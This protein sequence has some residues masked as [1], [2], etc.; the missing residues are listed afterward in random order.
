MKRNILIVALVIVLLIAVILI[1]N[2][3]IKLS[4]FS[5]KES[6]ITYIQLEPEYSEASAGDS[7]ILGVTLVRL[8]GNEAKD[9]T[10]NAII[11]DAQGLKQSISSQ[12]IALETRASLII[13]LTA[14]KKLNSNSYH[15]LIEVRDTKTNELLSVARQK[16]LSLDNIYLQ[17]NEKTLLYVILL[18]L[19]VIIALLVIIWRIMAHKKHAKLKK[20]KYAT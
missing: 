9:V 18:S 5:S 6:I 14:P 20:F 11:E 10:V 4:G 12:T 16:I 13:E 8:G 3:N 15:V 17:F 19:I 1:I 7:I 2:N